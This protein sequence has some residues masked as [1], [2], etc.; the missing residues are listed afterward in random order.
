MTVASVNVSFSLEPAVPG[1]GVALEI[2]EFVYNPEAHLH[3]SHTNDFTVSLPKASKSLEYPNY[4]RSTSDAIR[5]SY[6]A[7][8]QKARYS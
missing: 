4:T 8:A 3:A 2:T 7:C 5:H 6:S 1:N